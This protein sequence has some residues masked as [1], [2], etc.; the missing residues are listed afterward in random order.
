MRSLA[1][2]TG[3]RPQHSNF[4]GFRYFLLYQKLHECEKKKTG[5]SAELAAF[6]CWWASEKGEQAEATGEEKN[7]HTRISGCRRGLYLQHQKQQ[8]KK[9]KKKLKNLTISKIFWRRKEAIKKL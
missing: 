9:K 5:R 4:M 2:K 7:S 3:R 8:Q 6:Q 1:G